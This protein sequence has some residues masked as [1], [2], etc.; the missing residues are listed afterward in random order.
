MNTAAL[1]G[2][3]P[4]I[5]IRDI[6]LVHVNEERRQSN[7][8][9]ENLTLDIMENEFLCVV[10]PSGCGKSTL[11]SAIA[12][13]MQPQTGTVTMNG[14]RITKPGADR[15]VVFQEYALLPWK[16]VL[17][18]VALGLKFRGV[19][20]AD[21]EAK[22]MEY[23]A[24]ARLTEAAKKYPHELSG[25]MRQRA[26]VA[27]TLA[28]TPEIMMMD[29]PFAAVD[30]QTRLSLQEELLRVWNDNPITVLFITHSVE[31]A[32]FLADRVAVLTPGPGKLREIVEIDIPRNARHWD[33]IT[34]DPEFI[35]LR[36]RV[37]ALV[38]DQNG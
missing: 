16:T 20:R 15:G 26:A 13:F 35:A 22:A 17:D 6:T 24:M 7:V 36:D 4:K 30:A 33:T 34:S 5:S 37:M 29:E 21:R 25:G 2:G 10:G 12:G 18:N 27:R 3:T 23:I 38:R 9:V 31:E 19:P 8:A 28:N 32:V 1:T 14:E 11:L